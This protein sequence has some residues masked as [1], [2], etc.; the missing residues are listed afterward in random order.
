MFTLVLLSITLRIQRTRGAH[1][2]HQ[3]FLRIVAGATQA[4]IGQ[5][6]AVPPRLMPG[7]VARDTASRQTLPGS[8]SM[9][10]SA[11]TAWRP[12][13]IAGWCG[14]VRTSCSHR[15]RHQE[16]LCQVIIVCAPP[17]RTHRPGTGRGSRSGCSNDRPLRP[18]ARS[19][20]TRPSR[21]RSLARSQAGRC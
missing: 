3:L 12:C 9:V 19:R 10:E 18:G 21:C 16:Q 17:V 2:G 1:L 8:D 14:M 13:L 6:R 4:Q 5:R 11:C 20:G 15:L 7:A